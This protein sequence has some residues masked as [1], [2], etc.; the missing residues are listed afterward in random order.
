MHNIKSCLIMLIFSGVTSAYA[1]AGMPPKPDNCPDVQSIKA[2][3][4]AYSSHSQKGYTVA[5]LSQY[6]TKDTWVF[7][8]TGIDATSSEQ[9]L[10]IGANLLNTLYGT[11]QPIAVSSEKLWVCLY[12]TTQGNYGIA[13]TPVNLAQMNQLLMMATP[14]E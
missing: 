5:Q 11:P 8:F 2:E 1:G 3:G 10:N 12:N 7:G 9:A 4:L 13:L 6:N 14:K